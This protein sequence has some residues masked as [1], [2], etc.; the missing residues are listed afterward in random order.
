M[1]FVFVLIQIV[2]CLITY[3]ILRKW[4]K[5][6]S[7]TT[8]EKNKKMARDKGCNAHSYLNPNKQVSWKN[9]YL[10]LNIYFHIQYFRIKF[11]FKFF[12]HF[13]CEIIIGFF[14]KGYFSSFLF[15]K[16]SIFVLSATKR[17]VSMSNICRFG[18]KIFKVWLNGI[19][20]GI[21]S[22]HNYEYDK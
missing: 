12:H 4:L 11:F 17:I 6:L 16:I 14:F 20:R 7:S 3:F 22:S 10:Y 8:K 21:S 18:S 13:W 1:L 19:F 5:L 15:S 9:F 2:C